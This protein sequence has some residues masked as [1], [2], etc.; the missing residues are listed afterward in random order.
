MK[1]FPNKKIIGGII[2]VLLGL[3]VV[4]GDNTR[5]KY[6]LEQATEWISSFNLTSNNSLNETE[7]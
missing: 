7:E 5:I 4:F 1:K 3:G 6:Y 2:A